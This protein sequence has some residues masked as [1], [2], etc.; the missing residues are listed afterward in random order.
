M[1]KDDEKLEILTLLRQQKNMF[2]EKFMKNVRLHLRSDVDVFISFW[3]R[4]SSSIVSMMKHINKDKNF[5]TFSY[6]S[7]GEKS[8]E[9]WIDSVNQNVN[10]IS[11]KIYVSEEEN[12]VREIEK[13][14]EIQEE[15]FGSTS[16]Y[17]QYKVFGKAS[18][19]M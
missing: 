10:A 2:Q 11:N 6:I 9:K 13:I 15:P 14:I 4:S 5:N 3:G 19:K 1:G 18:K 7:E 16:I 12:I 17:A 8:E